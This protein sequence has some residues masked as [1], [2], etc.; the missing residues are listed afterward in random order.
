MAALGELESQMKAQEGVLSQYTKDL[1][2]Q[3]QAEVQKAWTPA[4]Q[5][6]TSATEQQMAQ[7]VPQFFGMGES[8]GGTSAVDLSPTQKLTQMGTTLGKMSGRLQATAKVS[9]YLGAQMSDMYSRAISAMQMGQQNEADKYSRLANQYQL[10][11]QAAEEEKNRVFQAEENAKSRAAS[12]GGGSGG[13]ASDDVQTFLDYA[14]ALN[15][16]RLG[17]AVTANSAF[18][19]L[20]SLRDSL[21]L[22]GT[23]NDESLWVLLGNTPKVGGTGTGTST[24]SKTTAKT[25]AN[26]AYGGSGYSPMKNVTSPDVWASNFNLLSQV[27]AVQTL[28]STLGKPPWPFNQ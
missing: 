24:T 20:K 13:A 7:Y 5:G 23:Y 3:I 19:Q 1:P 8:L 6:A 16:K 2:S 26:V 28:G 21:G 14:Q 25:Q 12:G 11:W 10:A 17:K 27:P 18:T 4:L 22:G 9:D 15:E